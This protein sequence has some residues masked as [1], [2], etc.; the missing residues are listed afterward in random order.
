MITCSVRPQDVVKNED[1]LNELRTDI[2]IVGGGTGG[3]AAAMAFC[4]LRKRE[5][6]QVR[7]LAH[8]AEFQSLLLK[9]G[10]CL[11]WPE[12]CNLADEQQFLRGLFAAGLPSDRPRYFC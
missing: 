6:S 8:L 10:F 1:P 2:L 12:R 11:E 5:P 7:E 9:E 4:R 3:I